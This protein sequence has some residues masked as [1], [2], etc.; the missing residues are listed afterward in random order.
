MKLLDSNIVIYATK[1]GFEFLEGT[2]ANDVCVS[3]ITYVEVLG[4]PSLSPT[5]S[6]SLEELLISIPLINITA[7][8]LDFAV[9]LR[10]RRRIKLADAF[11]AATAMA[12]GY[13]LV[14]RNVDDFKWIS[15]LSVI[16]PFPPSSTK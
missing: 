11:V 10:R 1:P 12:H 2:L 4:F 7:P 14:S 3:V 5:E 6:S 16:N 9:K 13:D 8:V 15:D